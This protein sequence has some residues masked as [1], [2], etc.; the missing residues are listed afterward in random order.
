MPTIH[1]M[2]N[3]VTNEQLDGKLN[4]V[5]HDIRALELDM[6]EIKNLYRSDIRELKESI[7]SLEK[8]MYKTEGGRLWLFSLL[9]VASTLG[10]T[11]ATLLKFK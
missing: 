9:T 6:K 2:Q 11:I 4:N 8:F 5:K 7:K 3:Y 10:G 1:N